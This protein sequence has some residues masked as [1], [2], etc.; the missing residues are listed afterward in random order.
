[1]ATYNVYTILMSQALQ[2]SSFK[3]LKWIKLKI[4]HLYRFMRVF[5]SSSYLIQWKRFDMLFNLFS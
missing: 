2:M 1:M 5:K 3:I 4:K